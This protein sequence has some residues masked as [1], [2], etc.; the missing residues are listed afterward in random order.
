MN[1]VTNIILFTT[2]DPSRLADDLIQ[3]GFN[4]FEALA[5][6]E[7]MQLC[8]AENVD[9]VL[10]TA[11]IEEHRALEIQHHYMTLRLKP[12][13]TVKE[14]IAELWQLFPDKAATVQ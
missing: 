13:A 5:I 1:C 9:I 10:I 3:A 14:I 12:N 7:V 6:S 8:E 11:E 4:V 2:S